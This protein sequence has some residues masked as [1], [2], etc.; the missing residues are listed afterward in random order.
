M[1]CGKERQ[2]EAD[3][4]V[5][6]HLQQNACQNDG[7][8]GGRFDVRIRQPGVEREHRDFDG[9]SEEEGEEEPDCGGERNL[10]RGLVEFRNA[11]GENARERVVME[12]EEQDAQQHQH[13]AEQRVE[14]ELDGRVKF[15]RAAPDA[16][17]QIH[18]D[19]HRFPENEEEEEI[20]RHE[21]AE[22]AGLENQEPDVVFLDAV[23]DGGP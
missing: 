11:E 13:G 5:G 4:A 7:A 2:R 18:R 10:R 8:G 20:E 3:E 12:I 21:D 22:H 19:Q 17:Q 15:A 14:E 9:E 23:L 16:D 1:T 6:S